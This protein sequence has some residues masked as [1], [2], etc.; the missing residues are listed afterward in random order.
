[1]T[2]KLFGIS[3][4]WYNGHFNGVMIYVGWWQVRIMKPRGRG[5]FINGSSWFSGFHRL[6]EPDD[7]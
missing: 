6:P 7:F 4:Q 2:Q 1:M 3:F 5:R